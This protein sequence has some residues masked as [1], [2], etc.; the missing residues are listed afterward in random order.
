MSGSSSLKVIQEHV[1]RQTQQIEQDAESSGPVAEDDDDEQAPSEAAFLDFV[2]L[3]MSSE[4]MSD[5]DQ[6]IARM[7]S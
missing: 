7:T 6:K 4:G 5:V 1:Q 3:D 2:Q